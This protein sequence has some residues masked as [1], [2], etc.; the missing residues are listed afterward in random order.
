MWVG[1]FGWMVLKMLKRLNLGGFRKQVPNLSNNYNDLTP[2]SQNFR[3]FVKNIFKLIIV[4]SWFFLPQ[5]LGSFFKENFNDK[6]SLNQLTLLE[7]NMVVSVK[8][9][10]SEGLN[11]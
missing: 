4:I 5:N 3:G 9:S 10:Y 1:K 2:F 6:G 8:K 7:Q 11:Q